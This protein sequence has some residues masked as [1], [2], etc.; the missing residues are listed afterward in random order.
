MGSSSDFVINF[1]GKLC[2]IIY[3]DIQILTGEGVSLEPVA[4]ELVVNAVKEED[5]DVFFSFN[6]GYVDHDMGW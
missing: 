5:N 2:K 3:L 4:V 1:E 6:R